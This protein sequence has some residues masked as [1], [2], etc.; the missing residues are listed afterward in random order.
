MLI[1]CYGITKSGSTLAFELVKG[2]LESAGHPQPRLPED[3]VNPG[4]R[5]NYIQ[6]LD[7]GRINRLIETVGER[8]IAVKTHAGFVDPLFP[9]FEKLEKKGQLR[10]IASYRDPREIC[11]SLIDA[12]VA[13]RAAGKKEFSEVRDL[14]SAI[15]RVAEQ[16]V[17]FRKW[18]ALRNT[19]RLD[20][21][22]VAFDTDEAIDR[23]E[24]SLGIAGNRDQAKQHAF[25]DAFTQKNR[26]Q[27]HRAR[28]EL[29]PEQDAKL[30]KAFGAFIENVYE[31]NNERWFSSLR[32][33]ILARLEA[34]Q[35]SP[36]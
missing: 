22:T 7:R 9:Y 13:S 16:I 33:S 12:G 24:H 11:L 30:R 36:P 29:S 27:R 5:I 8:W 26:A 31:K 15:P 23:I 25:A 18:A 14:D 35:V 6:P 32:K 4:H 10:V 2:I 17:K 28:R 19:L 34:Q 1:L 3:V 20:Y 21:D